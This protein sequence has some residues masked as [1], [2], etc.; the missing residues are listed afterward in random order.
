VK[1]P[2]VPFVDLSGLSIPASKRE[3][4]RLPRICRWTYEL[5]FFGDQCLNHRSVAAILP[6]I[7]PAIPNLT[8]FPVFG[9]GFHYLQFEIR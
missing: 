1:D 7:Y 6:P 9:V 8:R 4:K 5:D 3:L 2:G